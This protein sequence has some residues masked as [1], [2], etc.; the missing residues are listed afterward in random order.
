MFK[1]LFVEE[2]LIIKYGDMWGEGKMLFD[3]VFVGWFIYSRVSALQDQECVTNKIFTLVC[4]F[5]RV[6]VYKCMCI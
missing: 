3:F 5:I 4:G 1:K 2:G 6:C